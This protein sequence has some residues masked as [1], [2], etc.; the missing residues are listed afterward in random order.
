MASG[1]PFTAQQY[2][3]RI[4]GEPKTGNDLSCSVFTRRKKGRFDFDGESGNTVYF[5]LRYEKPRG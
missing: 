4:A 2:K 1:L 3:F 5:C